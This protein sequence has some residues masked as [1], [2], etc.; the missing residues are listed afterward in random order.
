[1]RLYH[2]RPVYQCE[3]DIAANETGWFSWLQV[4]CS[5]HL[6]VDEH[7]I[8]YWPMAGVLR[9]YLL[10]DRFAVWQRPNEPLRVILRFIGAQIER[11]TV[12]L[13]FSSQ[14]FLVIEWQL[15]TVIL[16]SSQFCH[17]S[18]MVLADYV[19]SERC[20]ATD[21]FKSTCIVDN[22]IRKHEAVTAFQL[23]TYQTT[24]LQH[25]YLSSAVMQFS[26]FMPASA[27]IPTTSAPYYQIS[28]IVHIL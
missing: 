16:P 11:T 3:V 19:F 13:Y 21:A 17:I 23:R 8:S 22:I 10:I 2:C 9:A 7:S 18:I 20:S 1:M 12:R 25:K 6:A 4:L 14:Q 28:F 15:V 27:E 24:V 26:R 5:L